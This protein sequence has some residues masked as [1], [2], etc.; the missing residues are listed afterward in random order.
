MVDFS[1]VHIGTIGEDDKLTQ[2]SGNGCFGT[3][4]VR[5]GYNDSNTKG[6]Y[7][8]PN[9][10]DPELLKYIMGLKRMEPFEL[11][12][13]PGG[14]PDTLTKEAYCLIPPKGICGAAFLNAFQ[15]L[16]STTPYKK[17]HNQAW[18]KMVDMGV[19]PD[20]AFFLQF[21]LSYEKKRLTA[22]L[23]LGSHS[24]LSS[25]DV[26]L[27]DIVEWITTNKALEMHEIKVQDSPMFSIEAGYQNNLLCASRSLMSH[28]RNMMGNYDQ[29]RHGA[30]SDA[31]FRKQMQKEGNLGLM[32]NY[33]PTLSEKQSKQ[34]F[35]EGEE[36]DLMDV[37]SI[38]HMIFDIEAQV[39][40]LVHATKEVS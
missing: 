14:G 20:V 5:V 34:A 3:W 25:A 22:K 39:K 37:K 35:W 36:P 7:Y 19:D 15:L 38:E 40:D 1:S 24:A 31:G 16:R 6:A 10:P 28:Y 27:K 23:S 30:K 21:N 29:Y 32:F 17:L 4:H 13:N 9:K 8:C 11:R 33:D 18:N 12:P 2:M 26:R